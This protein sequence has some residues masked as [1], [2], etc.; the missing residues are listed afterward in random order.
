MVCQQV[1][2]IPKSL[3]LWFAKCGS[4][5]WLYHWALTRVKRRLRRIWRRVWAC[6][7]SRRCRQ[8]T[9]ARIASMDLF[10]FARVCSIGRSTIIIHIQHHSIL[11][12]IS[13][14]ISKRKLSTSSTPWIH[15][16]TNMKSP[17]C[18]VHAQL[19]LKYSQLEVQLL[20]PII[21]LCI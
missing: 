15:T 20:S 2:S 9:S 3:C 7:R 1:V 19:S 13:S 10:N 12:S 17:W 11:V 4:T 8:M 14:P 16:C 21:I 18:R 6:W 5:M